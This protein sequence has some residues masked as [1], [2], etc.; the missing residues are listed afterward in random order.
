M[1]EGSWGGAR[2]GAGRKTREPGR[3]RKALSVSVSSVNWEVVRAYA[4]LTGRSMSEAA[5]AVL[6]AGAAAMG[7]GDGQVER[8]VPR[9]TIEMEAEGQAYE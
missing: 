4:D 3:P 2:A 7:L 9:A 6:S 5:D 1:T 8:V